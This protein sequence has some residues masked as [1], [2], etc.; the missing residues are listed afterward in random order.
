MTRGL[1]LAHSLPLFAVYFALLFV[2]TSAM[3]LSGAQAEEATPDTSPASKT[4][5]QKT[6]PSET[7]E[8]TPD[9]PPPATDANKSAGGQAP[10][11]ATLA[12]TPGMRLKLSCQTDGLGI[13]H[14]P[15]KSSKGLVGLDVEI[16]DDDG[17]PGQ[18]RITSYDTKHSESFAAYLKKNGL[19][20]DGC[21]LRLTTKNGIELWA[22]KPLSIDKLNKNDLLVIITLNEKTLEL[23]SSTFQGTGDGAQPLVFEKGTCEKTS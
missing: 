5:Q 1:G 6:E 7:N 12:V 22:P 18:W 19:C 23:K 17:K 21:P 11:G 16:G 2:S 15:P 9:A 20:S 8:A 14:A 13:G 10:A 3:L 4:E